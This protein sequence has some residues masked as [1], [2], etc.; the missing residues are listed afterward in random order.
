MRL[1]KSRLLSVASGLVIFSISTASLAAHSTHSHAIEGKQAPKTA[2]SYVIKGKRYY[3][4]AHVNKGY[5]QTGK[6]SWYDVASNFG[7]KTASGQKFDANAL[8]IASDELP[9][10]TKVRVTNLKNHK[11]VIA[12]VTDRG[13]YADN[14]IADLSKAAAAQLGYLDQGVADI[15]L[16]VI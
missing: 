15:K 1:L 13:P 10:F 3:P 12:T 14:R 7:T 2:H 6:A 16:T 9:M 4:M 5:T 11:S 8:T